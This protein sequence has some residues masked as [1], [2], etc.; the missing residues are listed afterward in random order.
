MPVGR[1]FD[2]AP[3]D[4]EFLRHVPANVA[5][6]AHANGLADDIRLVFDLLERADDLLTQAG[7]FPLEDA[8]PFNHFKLSH[9]AA[10]VRL[11]FEG[12]FQQDFE[13]T[14]GWLN[15]DYALFGGPV[16]NTESPLERLLGFQMEEGSCW[17]RTILMPHGSLW[18]RWRKWPRQFQGDAL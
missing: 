10:F 3:L 7:I 1:L 11:S 16:T 15:G 6:L 2:R 8:G 9:L 12:T 5:F 17:R 18:R 4:P 13:E 14:L